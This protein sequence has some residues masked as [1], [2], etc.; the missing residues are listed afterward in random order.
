MDNLV[1]LTFS[2]VFHLFIFPLSLALV[3][4]ATVNCG[5]GYTGVGYFVIN[6]CTQLQSSGFVSERAHSCAL[7]DCPHID[8]EKH[9][10]MAA[11][12]L[13]PEPKH[14]LE[15]ISINELEE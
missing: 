1:I 8:I 14:R 3:S 15:R 4:Q 12:G 2:T 10:Q 5:S 6:T 11:Y 7:R 9:R 13:D